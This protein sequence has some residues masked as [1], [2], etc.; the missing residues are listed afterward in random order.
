VLEAGQPDAVPRVKIPFR[1][2][3]T[4]G[5][6]RDWRFRSTAQRDVGGRNLKVNRGRTIAGSTTINSMVLF[7][8]K[9]DDFDN[10]DLPGW[11]RAEVIDN[12]EKT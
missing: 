11:D 7:R 10:R 12:F 2:L 3:Q 4:M 5:S 6:G 9:Q 8:G 1:L